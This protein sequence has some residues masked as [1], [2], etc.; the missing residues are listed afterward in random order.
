MCVL[1]LFLS[2][3][4]VIGEGATKLHRFFKSAGVLYWKKKKK[5]K[6]KDFKNVF[7]LFIDIHK[8]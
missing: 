3:T 4:E 1:V 7:Y 5:K 2:I 8:M 6:Y